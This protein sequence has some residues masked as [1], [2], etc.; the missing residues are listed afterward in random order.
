MALQATN[1][2]V[3]VRGYLHHTHTSQHYT[4]MPASITHSYQPAL[5]THTSQHYT[6]IPASITHSYQ[7][8]LHTH[9]SQHYTLIP[10]SITHSY[11][12]ALHTHTSQHYTLIPASITHSYQPALHTHTSQ[13]Y[14]LIPASITHSC[15][16]ALHTHTSQHYTLIPASITLTHF[17]RSHNDNT[18]TTGSGSK[19]CL[20]CEP[21]THTDRPTVSYHKWKGAEQCCVFT[22]PGNRPEDGRIWTRGWPYL[23]RWTA[24]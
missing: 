9:T 22:E 20:V 10:A 8:A 1:G 13:H 21:L 24:G 2:K 6:L 17:L 7:P 14:T 19:L 4:L 12:P 3:W 15:Q 11:Q 16:P 23:D 18:S 5:H